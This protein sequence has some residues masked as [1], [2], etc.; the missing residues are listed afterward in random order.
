[1]E[2]LFLLGVFEPARIQR[3]YSWTER[4]CGA[5]IDDLERAFR[6]AGLDPD[7]SVEAS[8]ETD[9]GRDDDDADE[10]GADDLGDEMA[11]QPTPVPQR[12]R[13]GVRPVET[14]Q[15]PYYLGQIVLMPRDKPN[16]YFVFDGQQRLTSLT[17]LL[18]VLRDLMRDGAWLP[19]QELIR[20]P[21]EHLTR[22]VAK[23]PGGNLERIAGTLNGSREARSHAHRSPADRLL[24]QA[25]VTFR[26]RCENW[27]D[28]KRQAFVGFLRQRVVVVVT[29]IANRGLA[30]AAYQTT[31]TRGRA[32]GADDVVKGYLVELVGRQSATLANNLAENWERV[33]RSIGPRFDQ[34]L[35]ASFVLGNHHIDE[36][37]Y[38][39]GLMDAFDGADAGARALKW[40]QEDLAANAAVWRDIH[41]HLRCDPCLGVDVPLRRLSF[42]RWKHW[43]P[44]AMRLGLRDRHAP[45]R[46]FQSMQ[47]LERWC[48]VVNLLGWTD[49]RVA[50]VCGRAV[51]QIDDK[52]N[53]F[54]RHPFERAGP[55]GALH[56]SDNYK[57]RAHANLFAPMEDPE[58]VGAHV[59]WLETLYWLD[60]ALPHAPTN[61]TS[62]EHVLPKSPT[63]QWLSDF[64]PEQIAL[65]T[66]LI[67]NLCLVP[68]RFNQELGNEQFESKKLRAMLESG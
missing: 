15:T 10:T 23:T 16:A 51:A 57:E 3:S 22:L 37:G 63:G 47:A 6:A 5:L 36:R 48:Y 26:E 55:Y 4:E 62:V 40:V 32:L 8:D 17:I 14:R 54:R 2:Q 12:T 56:I 19:L 13:L 65:C 35:E 27:S 44:V 45:Q 31:N 46:F 34:F 20:V 30:E 52:G 42:I 50:E 59:R 64:P 28:T 25:C 24:W 68:K 21:H 66:D 11:V 39:A 7:S 29:T 33:K 58:R 38:A 18:S 1:V 41:K 9:H 61:D 43:V 53:P 49:A 67:G 60:E